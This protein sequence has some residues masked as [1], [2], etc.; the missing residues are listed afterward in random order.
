M[1]AGRS[2]QRTK[3]VVDEIIAAGGSAEAL[4]IDLSSLESVRSAAA[5]FEARGRTIDILI[6]NAG[7]GMTKGITE[8]GFEVNFG[9]NHLGPFLLTHLLRRTLRP[10]TRIVSLSSAVHFRAKGIDFD[11]LRQPS[12]SLFGLQDYAVSK[13]ATILFTAEFARR[14][15]DWKTYAVHPGFVDTKIIPFWVKPFVRNSLVTPELGAATTIWCATDQSL[16]DSSG[17]YYTRCE[18]ATPSP[19]ARDDELARELWVQ[20]EHWCGVGPVN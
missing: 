15:P 16:S 18:E 20:S 4:Q 2:H 5:E 19:L 13:L 8:D 6:N 12:R 11:K 3:Q 9:V 17:G 10:G 1:A 7:I 14:Q